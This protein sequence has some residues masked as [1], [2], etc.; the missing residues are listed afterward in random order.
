MKKLLPVIVV[1]AA[2]ILLGAVGQNQTVAPNA[3]YQIV[4]NTEVR[5]DTFL[6]D[7]QTG[8]I[9]KPISYTDVPGTPTVWKY[10]D[11]VDNYDQLMQ[12][13]REARAQSE[14]KQPSP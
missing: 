3:R 8:K 10:Q 5:A 14:A 1:L 11:R 7:T 12:W 4:I 13:G 2:L 9:W 6:L